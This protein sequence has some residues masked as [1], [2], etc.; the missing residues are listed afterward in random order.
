MKSGGKKGGEAKAKRAE[1][2]AK[3]G[4]GEEADLSVTRAIKSAKSEER[5][6]RQQ[7]LTPKRAR[8]G[9]SEPVFR[10]H[11]AGGVGAELHL[12]P[13]AIDTILCLLT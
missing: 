8:E 11:V 13:A 6:L 2:D 1:K 7:G 4:R 10:D 12:R 9:A 3:K 5:R